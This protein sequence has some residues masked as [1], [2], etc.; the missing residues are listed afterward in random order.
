MYLL[1]THYSKR[2]ELLGKGIEMKGL[3]S[4]IMFTLLLTCTL[5]FAYNIQPAKAIGTIYIRANGS[6]DP[7]TAPIQR[8]GVVYTLTGNITS[9]A[10]GIVVERDNI[11]VDGSSFAVE[12]TGFPSQ[13]HGIYLH[14][15]SNV[16][17]QNTNIKNFENGIWLGYSSNNNTIENNNLTSNDLGIFLMGS[18]SFI[19]ENNITNNNNGITI[20]YSS[21]N[22]ISGN[23]I[24]N[25][26]NTGIWFY[27]SSN[28][29]S[30]SG[31]TIT[32]NSEGILLESSD[33]NSIS[34]NNI[35]NNGYYGIRLVFSSSNRVSGN[36]FNDAGLYVWSSYLN[37][38]ENNTV[39]GRP[40][41]YLEGIADCNVDDAG[42]V[43]LVKCD[44]IKVEDLNLSRTSVGVQ[45]WETNNSIVSGNDITAT[46]G[47]GISLG[48][49]SDNSIVG[50]RIDGSDYEGI[51]LTLSSNNSISG[52][53]ITNNWR[54]ILLESSNYNS[55]SRN[56]V[57]NNYDGI[58]LHSSSDNSVYN[59]DFVNNTRQV[60][61]EASTDVW[62]DGY[63]SG[64]NYWSDYNP[65]DADKDQ[66]GDLS[67]TIDANNTDRYP[68]I[69][70][71][72]FYEPEYVCSSDLN[73]DGIVNIIDITMVARAF[74][75][76]P[77]DLNWY[78]IADL[79]MNE[80]INIVD[81]TMVAKDYGKTV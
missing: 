20:G 23:T 43:V 58:T 68:L 57:T 13:S 4:K 70:P 19:Q 30:V 50:N 75:C 46:S 5:A 11:V 63:P 36:A 49:S 29:N 17:I 10:D 16:T 61:S 34:G 24:T 6:I 69:Y 71:F 18:R 73:K 79:N 1:I 48:I 60:Y 81:V 32:N 76:M 53:T 51:W 33:Y 55:I 52:N 3:T 67:Y 25:N 62:D 80:S 77:G 41:V 74:G 59:N 42:Q 56:T 9:D 26:H 54:G 40:L 31:N 47:K 7:P 2:V 15:I 78:P 65:P 21:S 64:G 38:V 22:S 27:A 66:I 45:L 12:G 35:T 72:E 37:S 39:N 14:E 44:R 8:N 28:N